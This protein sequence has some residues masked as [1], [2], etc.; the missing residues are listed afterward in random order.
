MVVFANGT[1]VRESD[2]PE[3][4]YIENGARRWVPD[5]S[6]LETLGGWGRVELVHLPV[7]VENPLGPMYPSAAAPQDWDD[8]S[9]LTAHPDPAVFVMQGGQRRWIPDLAT[10]DH[11]G[12]DWGQVRQISSLEMSL[13]PRGPD[14]DRYPPDVPPVSGGVP[15]VC[16][17][18][19]PTITGLPDRQAEIPRPPHIESDGT[20]T[21]LG[22][23]QQPLAA[24]PQL[25]WDTGQTVRVKMM[26]GTAFV[27][28]KVRR[29]AEEWTKHANL[30]FEFVDPSQPA[31]IRI[32]F[33]KGGSW[34]KLGRDALSVR[35]DLPTMNFGWFDDSTSDEEFRDTIL[36]EFG[37]ALGLVHEHQSPASGIQWDRE[38]T[39]AYFMDTLGWTRGMVDE[40]VFRR[41]SVGSTNY[42]AFD[43]DSIMVY[44]IPP[45]LTLDGRGTERNTQLSETDTAY[46]R[47]WYPFP[48]TPANA[49]GLLRPRDDCDEIDF[50]VEYNAIGA[51]EVG[52][53]LE[54]A[55]GLT[56]WK[57]IEVPIGGSQYR[58]LEIQ[59]G[60]SRTEQ[61]ARSELDDSR[62][63]RFW[64][65]KGLGIH[66]LLGYTW[67]VI[68]ALP[69]G[70][71]V[72]LTW[73]KDRC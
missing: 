64:K 39:Y 6:T 45:E 9:L 40:H 22:T 52:F 1:L 26:G 41:Y 19:D 65:A 27:R 67:D 54:A 13:I 29:F 70:S 60:T 3:V 8:G 15:L 36:H 42:S 50:L 56:W 44:P 71:R 33:A 7:R 49:D 55:S 61:I 43:P 72:R 10:F 18:R 38:K 68:S 23:T 59:D 48:V 57:A 34:S 2:R 24:Y 20:V 12:F 25:M 16:L 5:P 47:R 28:S 37:H 73:K 31:E 62:P 21:H 66:T 63:V 14:L 51:D 4:W 17:D 69:G 30:R 53:H 46:I 11:H 32:A 35:S 58:M